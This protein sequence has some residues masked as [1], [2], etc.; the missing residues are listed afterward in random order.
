MKIAFVVSGNGYGHLKRVC[1]VIEEIFGTGQEAE[2]M[3][4]GAD[5]HKEML[6]TWKY[7]KVFN[8]YRFLF[9]NGNLEK[10]LKAS[11]APAYT[12]DAYQA[13]WHQTV[14]ALHAFNP[15]RVISDNL[16]GIL[17]YYPHAMLMGSFLWSDTLRKK[18]EGNTEIEK[19]CSYEADLLT[20]HNPVMLGV[21]D[22]VMPYVKIHTRFSGLPWFCNRQYTESQHAHTV[23]VAGGGT[24]NATRMLLNIS[25]SLLL[26]GMF[27]VFLDRVL[28]A[29]THEGEKQMFS[30]FDFS[31]KN[32]QS[33]GWIVCRPG[34]GMLTDAI[35][36]TVP[37]CV[38]DEGDPEMQ[39]NCDRVEALGI[40]IRA[41]EDISGVA[42]QIARADRQ[43]C[44][45]KLRNR[46]TG[47]AALA[48]SLILN[49]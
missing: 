34:I 40:G 23:L 29:H 18:Y 30:L 42:D 8:A 22:M 46:K 1:T 17:A 39:F 19:I 7:A 6:S 12:F 24:Y 49:S 43:A 45:N 48:A 15:D 2:I 32:F 28:Y 26:S 16:A 35:Q 10:S 21:E 38:V 36:Y 13:S 14:S 4:I 47:G 11:I 25:R 20:R 9:V 37:L 31:E 3:M 41:A 5:T 27:T 33:L 44:I